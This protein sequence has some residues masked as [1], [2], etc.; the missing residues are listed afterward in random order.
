VHALEPEHLFSFTWHPYAVDP[1][2]DYLH[3]EPT[4]VE[5]KLQPTAN[6]TLLSVTESGFDK[7]PAHRRALAFMR[8]E[9]GWAQ[10]MQNIEAYVAKG[11]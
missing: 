8:N 10:Q 5:F 6:G 1:E 2:V 3:E 4:L 9:G 11:A 7:I